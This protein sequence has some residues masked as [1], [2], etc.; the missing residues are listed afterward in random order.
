M[1][2]TEPAR[3]RTPLGRGQKTA[4][5]LGLAFLFLVEQLCGD[6]GGLPRHDAGDRDGDGSA[7]A[8]PATGD[9]GG[10]GVDQ[11]LQRHRAVRTGALVADGMA[12]R[13]FVLAAIANDPLAK[14]VLTAA[15]IRHGPAGVGQAL[16]VASQ[17]PGAVLVV[18]QRPDASVDLAVGER[19]TELTAL[20]TP[21]PDRQL[22]APP[23]NCTPP[24][25][26]ASAAPTQ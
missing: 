22:V 17:V 24:T 21:G 1:T 13:G 10:A 19:F 26:A 12:Q 11:R 3:T 9:P 5:T 14:N 2:T 25:P 8:V 20:P 7:A 23:P 18:D 15:E 4:I 16:L 6:L